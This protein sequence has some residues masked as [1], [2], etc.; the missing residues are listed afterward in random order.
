M[1][2]LLRVFGPG[3]PLKIFFC[4]WRK[5]CTNS[6]QLVQDFATIHSM[7]FLGFLMVFLWFS[8][9]FLEFSYRFL[10]VSLV[11]LWFSAGFLMV[12]H[13]RPLV[14]SQPSSRRTARAEPLSKSSRLS[15]HTFSVRKDR[16]VYGYTGWGPQTLCLLVEL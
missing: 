11:F 16:W 15:G 5:S 9:G 12:F 7:F 8:Y 4:G 2:F 6:Y 14:P 10:V 13:S 3:F 1:V